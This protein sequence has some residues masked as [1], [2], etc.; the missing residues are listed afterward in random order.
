MILRTI[1]CDVCGETQQE[2]SPNSG[3]AG[4]GALHGVVLNGI[5]NPSLCP[6]CLE[7]TAA[8]VDSLRSNHGV[9]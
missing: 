8:F 7:K 6:P 9:D 1:K 2:A 5:P 3:W 4:W